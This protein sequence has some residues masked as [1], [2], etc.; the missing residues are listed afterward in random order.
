M[1]KATK[2]NP[3]CASVTVTGQC[4]TV[5]LLSQCHGYRYLIIY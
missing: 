4:V 1:E 5:S 2:R 3:A